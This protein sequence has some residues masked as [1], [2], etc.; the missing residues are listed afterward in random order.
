MNSND[1]HSRRRPVWPHA[2]MMVLIAP[3]LWGVTFGF[4]NGF[5]LPASVMHAVLA[6]AEWLGSVLIALTL[7][8]ITLLFRKPALSWLVLIA[9]VAYA[10]YSVHYTEQ[11]IGQQSGQLQTSTPSRPRPTPG[12]VTANEAI[13]AIPGS[14]AAMIAPEVIRRFEQKLLADA[15]NRYEARAREEG[16]SVDAAGYSATS[17]RFKHA[18]EQAIITEVRYPGGPQIGSSLKVI[19]WIQDGLLKRVSCVDPS[20]ENVDFRRG[21]CG[22]QVAE[23]FG[24]TSWLLD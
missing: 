10:A 8:W 13:E 6:F 21:R 1:Q 20:G 14:T 17:I 22:R 3:L 5:A 19:W 16:K 24:Y 11:M 15:E 12:D 4:L 18:G 7:A 2:L 23:T 9:A